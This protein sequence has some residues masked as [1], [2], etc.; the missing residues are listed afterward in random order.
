MI[1]PDRSV[2]NFDI[3]GEQARIPPPLIEAFGYIKKAAAIV[4]AAHGLDSKVGDAICLAADEVDLSPLFLCIRRQQL[5]NPIYFG[6]Y[7]S[8]GHQWQ[9][10]RPFPL[11][12]LS[13]RFWYSDQ[14]ECQRG[15]SSEISAN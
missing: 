7:L 9:V 3:G 13:N 5:I 12:C 14:H 11:G 10:E 1:L 4:N 6:C 15:Q 2:Q 8:V